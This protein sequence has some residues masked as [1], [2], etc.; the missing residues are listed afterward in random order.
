[1]TALHSL[2]AGPQLPVFVIIGD[3]LRGLRLCA[4][5]LVNL[6]LPLAILPSL[7]ALWLAPA[8]GLG[9]GGID[10]FAILANVAT[11]AYS[12]LALSLFRAFTQGENLGFAHLRHHLASRAGTLIA[13]Q[14]VIAL[15]TLVGLLALLA[16]GVIVSVLTFVALPAAL[17]ERLDWLPA[18]R[19]SVAL[20]EGHRL[21]LL[22]LSLAA[23]AIVLALLLALAGVYAALEGPVDPK[24][25]PEY[26]LTL[27]LVDGLFTALVIPFAHAVAVR[28]YLWLVATREGRHPPFATRG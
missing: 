11:L 10:P 8:S 4:A 13:L 24:R 12:L 25:P 23:G 15:M 17:F 3:A 19:R 28:A 7:V 5:P 14:L 2:G 26:G 21:K 1:M 16:P 18:L 9:G 27:A 22:A 6:A 20:S